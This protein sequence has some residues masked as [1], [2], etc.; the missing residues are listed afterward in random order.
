MLQEP[1]VS[2]YD[3]RFEILG[4]RVRVFWGFWA[5]ALLLGWNFSYAMM[6]LAE[7]E[8]LDSPG[9]PIYL[10]IW[11]AAIFI[12]ILVHELG[13]TMA[14]KYYGISSHIVLYHF[15]GLAVPGGMTDWDGARRRQI[16]AKEQLVI[17]AAG[18]VLQL[19]LGLVVVFC[20]YMLNVK[21]WILG[22][23]ISPE[24][25]TFPESMALFATIDALIFPSIAWALLNLVPV[26]P[27]DG[28]QIMRSILTMMNVHRPNHMALTISIGCAA[29]VGILGMMSGFRFLGMMML[30]MAFSNFQSLQMSGGY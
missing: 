12:S 27:L 15:G 5:M 30:F 22:V 4:Y 20:G 10:L 26:L 29:F 6:R 14:F 25:A 17:S 9:A 11:V 19:A 24:S 21:M 3:L 28:G 13:H 18:P 8:N 23:D 7:Q 16:G 1:P 2:P